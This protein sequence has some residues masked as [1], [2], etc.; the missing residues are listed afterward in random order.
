M[1]KAAFGFLL[2]KHGRLVTITRKGSPDVTAS[3]VRMAPSNYHRNT[4]GPSESVI[5]GRE[6]VILASS[7]GSFIPKRGDRFI[8]TGT[9]ERVISEVNEMHDF[10]G[11]VIGYRIRT[12]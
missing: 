10:G 3:D 1:I 11:E 7:L 8:F 2:S 9:S 12:S 5:P 4:E 6:F